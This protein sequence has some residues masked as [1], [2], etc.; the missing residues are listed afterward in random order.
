VQTAWRKLGDADE[1]GE[2]VFRSTSFVFW[3]KNFILLA[4]L[5]NAR[6]PAPPFL[7]PSIFTRQHTIR[8][9]SNFNLTYPNPTSAAPRLLVFRNIH[10]NQLQIQR[11]SFYAFQQMTRRRFSQIPFS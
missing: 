10:F 8:L 9:K 7:H 5:N 2:R 6:I 1:T 11:Y 3:I 4:L